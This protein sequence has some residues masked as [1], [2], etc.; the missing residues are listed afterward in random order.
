VLL[1]GINYI[2]SIHKGMARIK[3]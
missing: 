3:V 1:T 2:I